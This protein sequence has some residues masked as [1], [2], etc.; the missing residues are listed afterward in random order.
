MNNFTIL[1][2]M[3]CMSEWLYIVAMT[4]FLIFRS[5]KNT[6]FDLFIIKKMDRFFIVLF[7][8]VLAAQLLTNLENKKSVAIATAVMAL[9][10]IAYHHNNYF[11]IF[12]AGLLITG[13]IDVKA[14]R[15]LKM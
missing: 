9:S 12:M 11:D 8:I 3:R 13:C 4:L 2:K 1:N 10:V 14:D 5:L 6:T 7:S 15:T